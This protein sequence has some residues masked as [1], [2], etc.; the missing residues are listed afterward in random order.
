MPGSETAGSGQG[1][2]L[3]L[4]AGHPSVHRLPSRGVGLAAPPQV[5]RAV[6]AL[7]TGP[8]PL[9]LASLRAGPSLAPHPPRPAPA[10]AA[11]RRQTAQK[12]PS[13]FV[14]VVGSL[15]SWLPGLPIVPLKTSA[16]SFYIPFNFVNGRKN[17]VHRHL[18][19]QAGESLPGCFISLR[20]QMGCYFTLNFPF[21]TYCDAAHS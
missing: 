20:G 5:C 4:A 21:P 7:R 3:S 12:S 17:R 6:T 8:Q 11:R 10:P 16:N 14:P 19:S 9:P 1:G 13:P 2:V 18:I 15:G